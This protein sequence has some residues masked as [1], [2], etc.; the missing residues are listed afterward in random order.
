VKNLNRLFEIAYIPLIFFTVF[1]FCC[2]VGGTPK[3]VR[4]AISDIAPYAKMGG[5]YV[6]G[7]FAV[8]VL[9]TVIGFA[10]SAGWR[11]GKRLEKE[12]G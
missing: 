8:A 10:V 3:V 9:F 12:E 2:A 11:L 6:L 7:L 4:E 5:S 1:G